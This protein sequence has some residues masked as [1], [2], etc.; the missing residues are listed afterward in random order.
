MGQ[1]KEDA[2]FVSLDL[3]Q[4]RQR[5]RQ[6]GAEGTVVVEYVLPNFTSTRR[7][8]IRKNNEEKR[9]TVGLCL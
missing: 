2:C 6:R 7:G 1:V 4:D 8:F 5:V 3:Y 9:V